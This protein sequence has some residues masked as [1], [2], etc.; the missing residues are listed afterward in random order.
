MPELP[1]TFRPARILQLYKRL[2]PSFKSKAAALPAGL[3][4][5]DPTPKLAFVFLLLFIFFSF[6]QLASWMPG[7]PDLR[8]KIPTGP[9]GISAVLHAMRLA[10]TP[11]ILSFIAA[12]A[13]KQSRSERFLFTGPQTYL[14]MAFVGCGLIS[15]PYSYYPRASLAFVTGDLLK[16]LFLFILMINLLRNT[17]S[18]KTLMWTVAICGL[19]PAIGCVLANWRPETFAF[20]DDPSGRYGWVGYFLNPNTVAR[21][22]CFLVPVGLSLIG[23]TNSRAKKGLAFGL[24]IVYVYVMFTTLSRGSIVSLGLIGVI[25][26]ITSRKKMLT[27][28]LAM[29]VIIASLAAVPAV[30]ERVQTVPRFR[31]DASA[32]SR[33]KLWT[34]GVHFAAQRPLWG[35]GVSCFNLATAEHFWMLSQDRGLRWKTPHSSYVQVMAEMGFPALFIYVLLV[36][37]SLSEAR[38]VHKRMRHIDAPG[39]QDLARVSHGVFLALLSVMTVG[40]THSDAYDWTLY[41]LVA[42]CVCVKQIARRYD[43]YV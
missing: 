21:T 33:V 22:M 12:V 36:G 6:A 41:M 14:L 32:M 31:R 9:T 27:M 17:R 26:I 3:V 1:I 16:V 34:A 7:A 29:V 15:V 11:A 19:F 42:L 5:E 8:A 35:V 18:I 30:M 23:F 37:V 28:V 39:A 2:D 13:Y 4:E 38:K 10:L 25:Y 43:V 40:L 20:V 24:I